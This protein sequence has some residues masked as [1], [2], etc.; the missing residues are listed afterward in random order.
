M[1]KRRLLVAVLVFA[2]LAFR[3]EKVGT[4]SA[5]FDYHIADAFIT[6]AV[7]I[8]QIAARAEADNGDIVAVT[9]SGTFNA[10]S[11]KATEGGTFL[12]TTALGAVV[13]MGTWTPI[14]RGT[15]LEF[16]GCGVFPGG[17]LPPDV[18]GGILVLPVHLVS[19][20]GIEANGVLTIFC[21][22]GADAPPG[23]FDGITLDIPGVINFDDAIPEDTGLTVY[24]SRSKS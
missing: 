12:H 1:K 11:G 15:M 19:T 13:G 10:A 9:G 8:P 14:G 18:C 20:T 21:G 2:L 23:A 7:G 22:V 16:F 3:A 17:P 5:M 24:V 6:S 4:V